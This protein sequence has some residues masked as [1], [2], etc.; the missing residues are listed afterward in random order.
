MTNT[1]NKPLMLP[2]KKCAEHLG[3]AEHAVREWIK[4]G[5]IKAIPCGK[6]QLIN[7]DLLRRKL[8]GEEV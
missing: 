7:V 5:F 1:Q 3:I 6:K 4:S 2:P 8:E